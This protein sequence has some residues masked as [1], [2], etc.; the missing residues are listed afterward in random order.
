[1]L[2]ILLLVVIFLQFYAF[3]EKIIII[4]D[5]DFAPSLKSY[6]TNPQLLYENKQNVPSYVLSSLNV[7]NYALTHGY[8][9][10]QITADDSYFENVLGFHRSWLKL[11]AIFEYLSEGYDY[12]LY[13]DPMYYFA[14]PEV[15]LTEKLGPDSERSSGILLINDEAERVDFIVDDDLKPDFN[16]QTNLLLVK[17]SQNN[18]DLLREWILFDKAYGPD[19][20]KSFPYELAPLLLRLAKDYVKKIPLFLYD[21]P[22]NYLENESRPKEE[23]YFW[24]VEE[25]TRFHLQET[26][27]RQIEQFRNRQTA[28]KQLQNKENLT[29]KLVKVIDNFDMYAW[30]P[31]YWISMTISVF[32]LETK[33]QEAT[34][35][36]AFIGDTKLEGIH[37]QCQLI[38]LDCDVLYATF[39]EQQLLKTEE[40]RQSY[41]QAWAKKYIFENS[42]FQAKH[43]EALTHQL[44][45]PPTPEEVS[46]MKYKTI[47]A[48]FAGRAERLT[49]LMHYL[50]L[51][52]QLDIIQEI[53]I[54]DFCR[55]PADRFYLFDSFSEREEEGIYIKER[56]TSRL[57]WPDFYEYYDDHGKY[58]PNDIIV[59]CDD[60]LVFIDLVQFKSFIETVA[61]NEHLINGVLFPSIINN[62]VSAY[63]QQSRVGMLPTTEEKLG[64]YEYP[65]FGL[66]GSLWASG[67]KATDLHEYFLSHWESLV[68]PPRRYY[69]EI[70]P[71]HTRFSI[72][73]FA[74]KAKNWYKIKDTGVDDELHI[75]VSLPRYNIMRNY[76]Y[77]NFIVSQLSFSSQD[78]EMDIPELVRKYKELYDNYTTTLL[79]KYFPEVVLSV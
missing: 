46:H 74:M 34:E 39:R 6:I 49:I 64:E 26:V 38:E 51:A 72:N 55:K 76:F 53:H 47:V 10:R 45:T 20:Q 21:L 78:P 5:L 15:S 35:F 27:S 31:F 16:G 37:D 2:N 24:K 28:E 13:L 71:I 29:E 9:Y 19:W 12:V 66:C 17:Y 25:N 8:D 36:K 18:L 75:S 11:F 61:H 60:D 23:F 77:S 42:V 52:L 69:P 68:S 43:R 73:F 54:W 70:I 7:Y 57:F 50:A 3:S 63:L 48:V 40:F 14:F 56:Y 79:P 30:S 22:A 32:N 44:T 41:V 67:A 33:E 62:G 65:T 58:Y 59:K 4:Q 1:M